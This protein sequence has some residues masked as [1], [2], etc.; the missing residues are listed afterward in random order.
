MD[1]VLIIIVTY[2][3]LQ[4][5]WIKN[6]LNS[7]KQSD[8]AVDVLVIDNNSSDETVN[9]IKREHNN[10]ILV[11]SEGNLGFGKANNLGFEYAVKNE[12]DF[13]FLLNQDAY[14]KSDTVQ[15]LIEISKDNVDFAIISPI[16]LNGEGSMV[17]DDFLE[18][19]G[20]RRCNKF[21]SDGILNKFRNHLY[22]CD[23]V[24][25]AAWL[26]PISTLEKIGGF[27][28]IFF[29]Y[30]EDENYCQR[31]LCHK[32]KIGI[33]PTSFV[34]HDRVQDK[35]FYF[36]PVEG[37]FRHRIIE[38]A[39]PLNRIY[40]S[41]SFTNLYMYYLF[42]K[43][44]KRDLNLSKVYLKLIRYK[45]KNNTFLIQNIFLSK[46]GLKYIYLKI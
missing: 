2:N 40:E 7:I 3:G 38:W 4:H 16:Q 32:M 34:L 30:G 31:V 10:V 43:H 45:R 46:S 22:E 29:H 11:K 44:Y 5:N 8:Y 21:L 20:P 33:C 35:S 13:V 6:C 25:A 14:L 19:L 27:S 1:K 37:Q 24:M 12:Y 18:F 36:N 39:N 17:D 26:L 23:F 41:I 15:R 9:Y 42:Y 28:P